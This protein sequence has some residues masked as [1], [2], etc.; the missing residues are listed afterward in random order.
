[1][2]RFKFNIAKEDIDAHV[3]SNFSEEEKELF[4]DIKFYPFNVRC[5]ENM[6]IEI[7]TVGVVDFD[8]DDKE[9]VESES[10]E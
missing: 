7:T 5:N 1:M 10:Q 8:K 4:K 3:K 2:Y 9:T 6:D